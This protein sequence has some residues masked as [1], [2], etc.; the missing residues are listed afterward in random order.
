MRLD[1]I[2]R[3]EEILVNIINCE[4]EPDLNDTS[5]A[6]RTVDVS[7][8]GL[9]MSISMSIPVNTV[10]GLRLNL[11]KRLYRLEGEVRWVRED[12][13]VG[14]LLNDDSPDFKAWMEQF[15]LDF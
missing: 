15:Q 8:H 7:E 9:K 6:C 13:H 10:V 5:L 14:L 12:G 2:D 11:P 1:R 3:D 4:D